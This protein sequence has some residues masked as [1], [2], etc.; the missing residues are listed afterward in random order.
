MFEKQIRDAST[1]F[2]FDSDS[3]RCLGGGCRDGV[4]TFGNWVYGMVP[5]PSRGRRVI[6]MVLTH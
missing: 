5:E 2:G 6:S 1:L 4:G 3:A